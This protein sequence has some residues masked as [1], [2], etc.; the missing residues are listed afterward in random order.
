MAER[1]CQVCHFGLSERCPREDCPTRKPTMLSQM[2]AM[3][4]LEKMARE[5]NPK[6][7]SDLSGQV[8]TMT[9]SKE[10]IFASADPLSDFE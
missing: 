6:L 2:M 1:I 5:I 9:F 7:P 4:Q 10:G 8:V 3:Q